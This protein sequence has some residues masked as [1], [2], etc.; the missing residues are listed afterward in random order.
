VV[1]LKSPDAVG[2]NVIDS[3]P[4]IILTRDTDATIFSRLHMLPQAWHTLFSDIIYRCKSDKC[5]TKR[6]KGGVGIHKVP[7]MIS[8]QW[9]SGFIQKL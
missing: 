7:L 4:E 5:Q 2:L 1:F 6:S 3:L 9:H 8:G